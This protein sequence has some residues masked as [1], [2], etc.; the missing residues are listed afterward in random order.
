MLVY[1]TTLVLSGKKVLHPSDID[2]FR[3]TYICVDIDFRL[4]SD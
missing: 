2:L 3:L 4:F 1:A